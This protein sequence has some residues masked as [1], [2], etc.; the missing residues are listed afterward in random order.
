M[1]PLTILI[2][3]F[4]PLTQF[5]A[6]FRGNWLV[7]IQ[8]SVI[9]SIKWYFKWSE[10][11]GWGLAGR[12]SEQSPVQIWQDG[13]VIQRSCLCRLKED[14][15]SCTGNNDGLYRLWSDSDCDMSLKGHAVVEA[16]NLHEGPWSILVQ[17]VWDLQCIKWHLG[18]FFSH[19]VCCPVGIV[20]YALCIHLSPML[21]NL[22]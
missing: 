6:K 13:F 5:S 11:S 21:Y 14:T 15:A 10:L 3:F 16:V 12:D 8:F 22:R 9:P 18:R 19:Y 7:Q 17:S 1:G 4:N 2:R 20:P